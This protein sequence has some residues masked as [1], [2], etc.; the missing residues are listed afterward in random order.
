MS[1]QQTQV[2]STAKSSTDATGD[3]DVLF[4][5]LIAR[6]RAT[7]ADYDRATDMIASGAKTEDDL[8]SEWTPWALEIGA[9]VTLKGLQG[10]MDLNGQAATV[11]EYRMASRRF[12]VKLANSGETVAVRRANIED[13]ADGAVEVLADRLGADVAGIVG[14]FLTCT[15][16]QEPC[17]PGSKCRVAHPPH[18]R[19]ELGMMSGPDGLRASYGC[20]ACEQQ[21]DVVTPWKSKAGGTTD[22]L[23]ESHVQG[24]KWCYA[25]V[26]TTAP[27]PKSDQRRVHTGTVALTAGPSLQ[28]EIDA[29]PTTVQTLTIT[30]GTGFY[31][32]D[33]SVSFERHLPELR[34]L[35]LVD[36]AFSTLVLT[37]ALTPALESLRMQNVPDDCELT[38]E[39][40]RLKDVSIHFLSECDE[41]INAMLSHA[42]S[43]ESFDS[44][45]L[46]VSELHFASNEL[47]SV[48]LHRSDA[49]DT[50][51][52]YAP[53]LERLGLQACY[54]LDHLTFH[55]THPTLSALLP[56]GYL[57][58]PTLEV[59]TTNANLGARARRALR[60][61]PRVVK[62]ATR[63]QGMPTEAHFAG[64][65]AMMGGMMGEEDEEEDDEDD[66]EDDEDE[67]NDEDEFGMPGHGA[68][69]PPGLA[70][71]MRSMQMQEGG[72]GGMGAHG[73]LP[74]G[75]M[76]MMMAQ[77]GPHA[78]AGMMAGLDEEAEDDDGEEDES[79]DDEDDEDEGGGSG[80][81]S[82]GNRIEEIDAQD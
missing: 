17:A 34:E 79:E 27:M 5:D 64:L 56:A 40:P 78:F 52:L 33:L 72:P 71:M 21:Y 70:E 57:P 31:D 19:Q 45:K 1:E 47:R 54:G 67:E 37:E 73:G 24:A 3:I 20:A 60:E 28:A 26:H 2:A 69:I 76:E 53:N 8:V 65:G 7:E 46:W 38:L 61:H 30:S 63:H 32:D 74:P 18:L 22:G 68:G 43:L 12:A 23:G 4:A 10:R 75:F 16:C 6:E 29:L 35:Q 62:S 82:D 14:G 11:T 39:L 44:Y 36:V 9:T 77:M 59:N 41:V 25:G 58:P 42:T 55:D 66:E 49:L 48:D 15:R 50:L 80:S 81:G 13:G 51:T